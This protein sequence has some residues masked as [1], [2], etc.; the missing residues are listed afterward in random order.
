MPTTAIIFFVLNLCSSELDGSLWNSHFTAP[1]AWSAVRSLKPLQFLC[2]YLDE[3]RIHQSNWMHL[4]TLAIAV[5][6]IF[7][8]AC[9]RHLQ[10][11]FFSFLSLPVFLMWVSHV[12]GCKKIVKTIPSNCYKPVPLTGT[13]EQF[14]LL[15]EIKGRGWEWRRWQI[16]YVPK[17]WEHSQLYGLGPLCPCVT[18]PLQLNTTSLN[19]RWLSQEPIRVKWSHSIT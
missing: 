9:F 8:L 18:V 17:Y 10:L 2:Y 6:V 12:V 15:P 19:E 13:Q 7:L 14:W 16:H 1:S 5:L 4:L 3:Q 11:S